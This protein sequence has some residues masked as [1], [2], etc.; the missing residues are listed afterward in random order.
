MCHLPI[1]RLLDDECVPD[2]VSGL[3]GLKGRGASRTTGDEYEDEAHRR[4]SSRNSDC[5]HIVLSLS[6][7]ADW[8]ADV[9][10]QVPS[11]QVCPGTRCPMRR[12]LR[13][14]AAGKATSGDTTTLEDLNVLA[15]LRQDEE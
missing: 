2:Q 12:L 6:F 7:Q 10:E 13:E 5:P 4:R 8:W 3:G 11:R 14:V 1:R 9:A 15:T